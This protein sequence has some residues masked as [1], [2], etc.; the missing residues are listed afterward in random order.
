M[1]SIGIDI[2]SFS[3][4]V[5]KVR[6]NA[7]GYTVEKLSEYPISQDPT[8]DTQIEIIEVLRDIKATL[9]EEGALVVTGAH[10]FDVSIRR[11]EFPFRERH[12]I[13]K[14]LPFELEDDIPFSYENSVF[15]A[16]ITHFRGIT[17]HL[18][19]CA[20]PKE[21]VQRI[22]TQ[23]GDGGIK[24]DII[25]VDSI[26][27]ASLFEEWREAPWEYP[28]SSQALPENNSVDIIVNLGHR[29]TTVSIIKDGYLLDTRSIDW[30][31][32]DLAEII[33]SKYSIHLLEALKE[34]RR[35]A[36]ILTNNEGATREQVALSEIIKSSIDVLAQ[37]LRLILFELKS[38]YHLDFRQC[39]LTGGVSQ[40]RNLGPY[41]TQKLEIACNRLA[42]LDMMNSIDFSASP[43]NELAAIT[44]IGLAVEGVKRPKNPALDLLK[45]EFAIQNQ[46]FKNF[47]EKWGHA[48]RILAIVFFVMLAWGYLK[49]DF[50]ESNSLAAEDQLKS[51]AK[52]I[53]GLKG[54]KV[55]D[56]SIHAY[57]KEQEQKAKLKE[58]IESLQNINSAL[59]VLKNISNLAP[60]KKLGN[61]NIFEFKVNSDTVSVLGEASAVTSL[62]ELQKAIKSIALN[63]QFK[64]DN[65]PR[66]S[67]PGY[68]GFSYNFKTDRKSG[69]H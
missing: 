24:P 32:K 18:L 56:R 41:L 31:G 49:Q 46:S 3:I 28:Q 30:G 1:V 37:K 10:Q 67:H 38:E 54:P 44:S 9:W 16:K 47:V 34:L 64:A 36:F 59:D 14:S 5:A 8:K 11:K 17:T 7:R 60:D 23:L 12:K 42:H 35:K 22:I 39:I 6:S 55:N 26:A 48:G 66:A 2:G 19:A 13:L 25:S 29:T 53:M 20:C 50:S 43:N 52:N 15:D 27:A 61:I 51:H 68:K 45:G 4:K 57:I 33:S 69:S 21:H 65:P 62:N 40:L 58:L 63:G